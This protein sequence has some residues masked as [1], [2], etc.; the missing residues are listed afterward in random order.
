M[1]I[2]CTVRSIAKVHIHRRP[3][4]AGINK[5]NIRRLLR[6]ISGSWEW[7]QYYLAITKRDTKLWTKGSLFLRYVTNMEIK[8]KLYL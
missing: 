6:N 3:E 8:Y 1:I 2:S 5:K 7:K 4:N